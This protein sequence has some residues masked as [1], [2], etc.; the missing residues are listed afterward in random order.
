MIW[1]NLPEEL[2]DL[3][4]NNELSGFVIEQALNKIAANSFEEYLQLSS[5]MHYVLV[6]SHSDR[7]FKYPELKWLKFAPDV[8]SYKLFNTVSLFAMNI[9]C[10]EEDYYIPCA[11]I[12]KIFNS[13]FDG[14]NLFLFKYSNSISFG[15]ARKPNETIPNNFTITGSIN[16]DT[17][18][19]Y[20][21][22]FDE[23]QMSE[24]NDLPRLIANFS[25][26][27]R[28]TSI[29]KD[30]RYD[31]GYYTDEK[32]MDEFYQDNWIYYENLMED[33][34][35]FSRKRYSTD[36]YKDACLVLQD[37]ADHVNSDPDESELFLD[38]TNDLSKEEH[39]PGLE[40]MKLNEEN[41]FDLTI[42]YSEDAYSNA[43]IMLK[44]MS[45]A[46]KNGGNQ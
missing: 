43:E 8:Y 9:L 34:N 19:Q 16:S 33:A 38:V 42:N 4:T 32:D 46:D 3:L 17:V 28:S 37:V 20:E 30:N 35:N 40:K 11:A 5:A 13:V 22:F 2:V 31:Y 29:R 7:L 1:D 41:N 27:E 15:V 39:I 14:K 44:E 10:D 23:L 21:E 26:Q 6:Y 25:P 18:F 24:F 12:T 36:T 45:K